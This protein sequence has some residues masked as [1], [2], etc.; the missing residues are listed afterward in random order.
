M[1][2]KSFFTWMLPINL[3]L[4]LSSFHWYTV[5]HL[6]AFIEVY[7]DETEVRKYGIVC[8]QT[9]AEASLSQ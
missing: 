5:Y 8:Q 3:K 6:G 2:K 4:R 7:N 9:S 1:I